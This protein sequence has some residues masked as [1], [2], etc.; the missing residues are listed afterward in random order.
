M[1]E[2][3]R[4]ALAPFANGAELAIYVHELK[5]KLGN[6]PTLGISAAIHGNEPTGTHTVMEI[7]KRY[8]DGNF[9]GRLLLLPVANP[10][11]FEANSRFT[12]LDGQDL[13]RLFP[14]N[15]TGWFTEHLAHHITAQFLD[16]LDAY[17]DLHSGTDRPTVD[18]VYIHN[19]EALSRGFGSYI[20]FEPEAD[21]AGPVFK[22]TTKSVT[23]ARGVPS[24]TVELGGGLIDQAPYVARSVAGIENMMRVLGMVDEAPAPPMAQI[25]VNAITYVRPTR[26]G[27]L[28]TEAPP[29]GEEI[30]GG[31]VLGR[32]VS[33]YTFEELEVIRSA[34]DRGIMILSH[35]TTNL[36]QPGDFSY[37]VGDL[38]GCRHLDGA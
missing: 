37:M 10:L 33:P 8:A 25:V 19:D 23:A 15:T 17:V 29:L 38:D 20:L 11:A 3:R 4:I 12:P 31:S 22:A 16:H 9:R 28:V 18:Y 13:N 30:A 21:K 34:F 32:V 26:G 35:L 6:G 14:G 7:A 27:F 2:V 1:T 36:V 5:G 24:V